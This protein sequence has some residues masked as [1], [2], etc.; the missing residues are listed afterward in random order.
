[1][2]NV[3]LPQKIASSVTPE[4]ITN[5]QANISI[6]LATSTVNNPIISAANPVITFMIH[7]KK[8][9]RPN[10]IEKV[11]EKMINEINH[12]TQTL[13]SLGYTK[14]LALAARYCLCTCIDET[15][16]RTDWGT[17]TVWVQHTLLSYFHNETWGGERFYIIL[18]NLAQNPRQ[19][20]ATLELLYLLLSLGF[21]GKFYAN[22]G[23]IRDDVI[24]RTFKLIKNTSGKQSRQLAT[25]TQ[26]NN[27]IKVIENKGRSIKWG[28]YSL[29]GIFIATLLIVNIKLA[30]IS[31][32]TVN[33]IQ[34]TANGAPL[35]TFSQLIDRS[36]N[37]KDITNE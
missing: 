6:P 30:Q 32:S 11:R 18:D 17:Q 4:T 28:M 23:P 8:S 16:L 20:I 27:A 33:M 9:N 34:N 37:G 26:D 35:T 10:N 36:I 19:N 21:E 24:N 5:N 22:Q 2:N 31:H 29:L 14:K 15:I 13:K 25:H 3:S 1:M 12:F 7:I